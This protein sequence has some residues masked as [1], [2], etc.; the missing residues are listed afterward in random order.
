SGRLTI[1]MFGDLV[2][3]TSLNFISL[4]KGFKKRN[5]L[6]KYAGTEIHRV[7]QDFIIQGGDVTH[8]NGEG[9]M[10]LYGPIF[11]DENYKISHLS[12]GIV[13]MAN[14]GRNSNASQFFILLQKSRWLNQR[15]VAF[16][17]VIKG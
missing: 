7:V 14:Y 11:D 13:S 15:H 5:I 9:G 6:Y 12:A 2:P 17:K 1:A 10:S 4:C 3:M 16:G 8:K